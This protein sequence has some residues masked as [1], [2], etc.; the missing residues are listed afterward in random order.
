MAGAFL[1]ATGG[2]SRKYSVF[3]GRFPRCFALP[4][5]SGEAVAGF[6]R[7]GRQ[8]SLGLDPLRP[9]QPVS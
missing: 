9:R 8:S 5:R 4:V 3:R 2:V 7:P 1:V 6:D